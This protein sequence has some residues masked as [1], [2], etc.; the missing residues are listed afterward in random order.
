MKA[1][2]DDIHIH[3]H[4]SG[5]SGRPVVMLSHSLATQMAMWHAQLEFLENRYRILRYDTR[6]HGES[7]AP[8]GAYSLERL[9]ED[10]V[11]LLDHL[12]IDTVM[13]VG[14]SM[15]GMIGQCLAL[16]HPERLRCLVLSSTTAHIPEEAQPIWQERIDAA[17]EKGM[18][19]LVNATLDRWFTPGF[20]KQQHPAVNAIRSLI[21]KTPVSGYVGCSQAIRRLN[22]LDRLASVNV[23]TLIMV[24]EG[25]PGTPVAASQAIQS[26]ITKS[27]LVIVPDAY[28]LCNIE[29][30]RIFNDHLARFLS[31]C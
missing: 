10:A 8:S 4:L 7:D 12:G 25:D 24:G 22:L 30:M 31:A 18:E 16:E 15:G 2:I 17:L 19:A 11:G 6:G 26:R 14:L 21:L 13:F 20:I 27:Q 9:A 3:Y 1:K 29:Q 23:P 5:E 28:H